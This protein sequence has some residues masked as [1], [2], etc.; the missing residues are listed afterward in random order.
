MPDKLIT[1]KGQA[2]NLELDAYGNLLRLNFKGQGIDLPVACT[3]YEIDGQESR[4]ELRQGENTLL[5]QLT[6]RER[7][8]TLIFAPGRDVTVRI[9]PEQSEVAKRAGL[10]LFFP[11]SAVLHLAEH[12]NIG[13]KLEADMPIGEVVACTLN[14]NFLLVE[15]EN[16]ILM[17]RV[18]HARFST[19][20]VEIVRA[21]DTFGVTLSWP[22]ETDLS[23]AMFSSLQEAI[24][25]YERWM[26]ETYQ[27]RKLRDPERK[28]PEWM[29][30]IPLIITVDMLRSNWEITHDYVDLLNL[31]RE[32]EELGCPK[33][34]LFYIPGWQGAYDS[35]HPTYW[36]R[37]E[38]GG[39]GAFRA[40][41]D[42]VH[43][44]GYRVMI[45]ATGWGIDPYH[46]DIDHLEKLAV[47]N[48]DGSLHGWQIGP[49]WLPPFRSL[50]FRTGRLPLPAGE[51]ERSFT[52]DTPKIPNWCEALVRIGGLGADQARVRLTV[53]RRSI[54]SPA[55]WFKEHEAYDYPYP[56]LLQAGRNR[57][58]VEATGEVDW[59]QGW[60][61]LYFCFTPTSPYSSWTWPILMADMANPEY[62]EIFSESLASAVETFQIDAVHVDATGLDWVDVPNGKPLLEGL[63]KRLPDTPICSEATLGYADLGFAPLSQGATQSLIGTGHR[64]IVK[65][66]A[67]QGSLAPERN[68]AEL[69]AWLNKPSEVCAFAK[70]YCYNYPHLCAANAFVPVGKVCNIFPARK[71]PPSSADLWNIL[72]D[73]RRLDYIPGLRL[74][75]REYGLDEETRSAILE[76]TR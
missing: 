68:L 69:F 59:S 7:S 28:V 5:Y 33:G 56:L 44:C 22:V 19:A 21:R 35:T 10:S 23:L 36:P 34:T 14:Y 13:R 2:F 50:K 49:R 26:Q 72:R 73:A 67:E 71:M 39:E 31:A 11:A 6:A 29:H 45:H 74:N 20:A 48:P 75:F 18:N 37:P 27:V 17:L 53:G 30:N 55:G 70:H 32:L 76:L 54:I 58:Q 63:R 46:P 25:D 15:M 9:T 60:Y 8:G 64:A 16:A 38:L 65:R 66:P 41:V 47:R 24:T 4:V 43:A 52:F 1:V 61:Q 57:I 62:I 40:M 12:R 3:T 42:G 51:G